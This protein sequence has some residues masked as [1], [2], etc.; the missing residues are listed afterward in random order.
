MIVKNEEANLAA[1]LRSIADLVDEMNVVDTGSTDATVAIAQQLGAKVS[2]FPW[3]DSFAAARNES[4]GTPRASGSCGWT[5]TTAWPT[6]IARSS[7]FSS[8]SFPMRTSAM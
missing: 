1:C 6:R 2:D 5:P 7:A 8:V 3:I 4:L